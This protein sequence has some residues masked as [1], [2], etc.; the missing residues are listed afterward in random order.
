MESDERNNL[1][2]ASA[3]SRIIACPGSENLIAQ[4]RKESKG[5]TRPPD[6]DAE[7]GQDVHAVLSDEVSE[8]SV[9]ERAAWVA[10]QCASIR[11]KILKEIFGDEEG[12]KLFVETRFWLHDH[13]GNK[14]FSAKPD[15]I[16]G[17]NGVFVC[18]E[19]K[20]LTGFVEP[21][22][23]NF[24]IMS[25]CTAFADDDDT[26]NANG[27][28]E[29]VAM[30]GAVIQPLLGHK[31]S[32]VKFDITDLMRAKRLILQ[33]L[34]EAKTI[35]APRIPGR[36]CSW[37]PARNKCPEA[38]V[39]LLAIEKRDSLSVE[40]LSPQAVAA[41]IPNLASLKKRIKDFEAHAKSLAEQNLL[42]GYEIKTQEGNRYIQSQDSI[43]AI[44]ELLGE[45]I[46]VK[47]IRAM[48][49]LPFGELRTLAIDKIVARDR[50]DKVAAG[51]QFDELICQHVGREN[52]KRLLTKVKTS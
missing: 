25:Q 1:P 37:C 27:E 5:G 11:A 44:H 41:I 35:G 33:K 26:R 10:K 38:V 3:L 16:A 6:S 8:M 30:Y 34:D 21:A 43:K 22:D 2:S 19:Y 23:E 12:L 45:Y 20:S 32:L 48:V 46:D 39:D 7:F 52:P 15:L 42:P 9:P 14:V 49:T 40:A 17:K 29:V 24:Q 18:L 51:K 13:A 28:V 31:A 4:L 47:E 36:Q 50:C